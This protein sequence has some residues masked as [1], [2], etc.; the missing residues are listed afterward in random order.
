MADAQRLSSRKFIFVIKI[1]N[2]TL[3]LVDEKL[4]HIIQTKYPHEISNPRFSLDSFCTIS[5]MQPE[6]CTDLNQQ[7]GTM[8]HTA[9]P[10]AHC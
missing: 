4:S 1:R 6:H 10:D 7:R 5:S 3:L 2:R 8:P 9:T